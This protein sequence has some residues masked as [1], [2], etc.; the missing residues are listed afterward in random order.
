MPLANAAPDHAPSAFTALRV[1]V[2]AEYRRRTPASRELAA[3][4]RQLLP[5]GVSGNLRFFPPYPFYTRRGG[6]IEIED[7]D[8]NRYLDCF[9]M[10]GPL[11]LGHNHPAIAAAI[12]ETRELGSLPLNPAILV[13]AAEEVVRTVPCAERVRFLNTGTEAVIMACRYARAFT[14]RSRIVKF[15]GHYHGQQDQFLFGIDGSAAVFSAGVPSQVTESAIALPFLDLERV[16]S[17]LAS[18]PDIAAVILD[19]AMHAGGLWGSAPA[20]LE[21]L[22][23]L[24]RDNGVLLIFD[25]VITGCRLAAGGAQAY[26][27]VTPDLA[28]FAKALGAGEKLAAVCGRADIFAVV[29]PAAAPGTPRVFQS[30]TVNDGAAALAAAARALALYREKEAAGEYGRLEQRAAHLARALEDL[31]LRHRIRIQVNQLA[32]M[33]QLYHCSAPVDF[34][35]AQQLD[36]EP[37]ELFYLAMINEGVVLSLPRS[38]HIYLSFLHDDSAIQSILDAAARVLE[39]YDFSA[40]INC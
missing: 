4:A 40:A 39:R 12:A 14:G 37:L 23:R 27:G 11:L 35:S 15:L 38:N 10:N 9:G 34:W 1:A 24:C 16:S 17:L 5:G 33:L 18:D 21:A 32:S 7:V 25:E 28:T 36:Y 30:G 19:P 6:G 31:F 29:D 26:Y 3:R 2:E 13:A 22:G 20:E 8:G